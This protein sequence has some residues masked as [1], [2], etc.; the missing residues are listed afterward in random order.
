MAP[1]L[2]AGLQAA[3]EIW[4]GAAQDWAVGCVWD[5]RHLQKRERVT[6][7]TFDVS[8]AQLLKGPF[9]PGRPYAPF[10]EGGALFPPHCQRV[11]VEQ[12]R[13]LRGKKRQFGWI[14]KLLLCCTPPGPTRAKQVPC[15]P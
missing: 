11:E 1:W 14:F 13:S 10:G 3:E 7:N 15:G 2:A 9:S 8:W 12:T 4:V 5:P 6:T